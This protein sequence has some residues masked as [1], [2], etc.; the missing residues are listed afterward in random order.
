VWSQGLLLPRNHLDVGIGTALAMEQGAN[1]RRGA[2]GRAHPPPLAARP[3]RWAR[4]APLAALGSK[5]H[6]A[7]RG[8]YRGQGPGA[9]GKGFGLACRARVM[10]ARHA[11]REWRGT[12]DRW[13][14]HA[15]LQG[16]GDSPPAVE[17]G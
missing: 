13:A 12:T 7:A 5:P 6:Q 4:C 9:R 15:H 14:G 1:S 3:P 17:A 10:A 8:G 11:R 2:L 16:L